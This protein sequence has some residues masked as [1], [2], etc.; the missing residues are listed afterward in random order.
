[1]SAQG[2][3]HSDIEDSNILVTWEAYQAEKERHERETKQL[4]Y[5]RIARENELL[6]LGHSSCGV[7]KESHNDVESERALLPDETDLLEFSPVIAPI[8]APAASTF[9]S[10]ESKAFILS[11]GHLQEETE[12]QHI[13]TAKTPK[14]AYLLHIPTNLTSS[15]NVSTPNP[16]KP[17]FGGMVIQGLRDY[18]PLVKASSTQRQDLNSQARAPPTIQKPASQ[19]E[20]DSASDSDDLIEL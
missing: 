16:S 11:P 2:T 17:S 14:P 1:M 9:E 12:L 19:V 4:E 5:A 8:S 13:D 6:F 20:S 3:A 7:V 18:R 10:Q 15:T